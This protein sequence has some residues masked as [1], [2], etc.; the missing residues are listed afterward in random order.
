MP[1]NTTPLPPTQGLS[2]YLP[3]TV[4]H[5]GS[6]HAS[7]I[8]GSRRSEPI[9]MEAYGMLALSRAA[10]QP[11]QDLYHSLHSAM[12]GNA[13]G[14]SGSG[15]ARSAASG[16]SGA[17]LEV[18]Q[19]EARLV[20]SRDR[21]PWVDYTVKPKASKVPNVEALQMVGFANPFNASTVL[22]TQVSALNSLPPVNLQPD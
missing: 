11:L 3:T 9:T 16:G 13:P 17:Q 1:F 14:S 15:S 8:R 4:S 19:A 18:E 12:S 22:V 2:I 10:L 5:A 6:T 7:G 20:Q 21:A